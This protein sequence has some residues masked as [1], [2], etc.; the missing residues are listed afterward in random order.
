MFPQESDTGMC[1]TS[2]SNTNL[3][4]QELASNMDNA[5]TLKQIK[6]EASHVATTTGI[7]SSSSNTNLKHHIASSTSNT[8]LKHHLHHDKQH[9]SH[10]SHSH[11][12][13]E[14][15]DRIT[16]TVDRKNELVQAKELAKQHVFLYDPGYTN[17]AC[18][19]SS[20]TFIDG[21][22]G[23]L[24][25]RGYPIEQVAARA[26]Y[27]DVAWMLFHGEMP[28]ATE[29]S[30]FATDIM[31]KTCPDN[32]V[33]QQDP[34]LITKALL[35]KS[36]Y[37]STPVK[38][39]IQS[40]HRDAHPMGMLVSA[41]SAWGTCM[42]QLNPAYQGNKVYESQAVRDE[43]QSTVLGGFVTIAAMVYHQMNGTTLSDE[44]IREVH[45]SFREHPVS[46]GELFLKLIQKDNLPASVASALDVL[47]ILHADHELNCST[48]TMRQLASSGVDLFSCLAGAT[49]ALYGPL[50]GGATEAVLRMLEKIGSAD[51]ID[52]F[53]QAVKNRQALL[54]GFG[55][56][57]Y[58]N[59]DPRATLIRD[60]AHK[61]L[62]DLNIH[63]SPLLEIAQKLETAALT[64][65]YFISRKLYPNVDFYSGIIYSAIGF[66]PEFF[67]VLFALGR[68]SGWISHWNEFMKDEW[69]EKKICRPRQIYVGHDERELKEML[70]TESACQCETKCEP[71]SSNGCK[72]I[73]KAK[74]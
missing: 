45:T 36:S 64:D 11:H 8:N 37:T 44:V 55:H 57:I 63:D 72:T 35:F 31:T 43:V 3:Q 47:L 42:P 30:K 66:R 21:D 68:V 28:T 12:N 33:G 41:L 22:L 46:Y 23:I 2:T 67:P 58:K 7:P 10:H 26:S 29:R 14:N 39:V 18:C 62:R 65:Q 59:Y 61:V 27:V 73:L 70:L 6:D 19:K 40:M 15:D 60:I 56:R 13:Q 71:S 74:M 32:I 1:A 16:I 69:N 4:V 34:S 54:M 38:S 25:Y 50:H 52:S 20:I 24:R 9:H 49:C 17:T 48:A 51:N 53:L 5:M